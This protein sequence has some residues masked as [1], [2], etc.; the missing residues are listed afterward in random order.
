LRFREREER[1]RE[2]E[3]RERA[4]GGERQGNEEEEGG[5]SDLSVTVAAK[6]ISWKLKKESGYSKRQEACML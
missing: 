1:R 4:R 3:S 2:G 5:E 6:E